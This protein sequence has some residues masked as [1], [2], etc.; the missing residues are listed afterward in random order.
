MILVTGATGFL[1]SELVKQLLQRGEPVRAIKRKSSVIPEI[2]QN[3]AGVEWVES[4]LLDYF[5][6]DKAFEGVNRVYHC[7]A[8]VAFDRSSK[9]KM[10]AANVEG[11]AHIVELCIT[12]GI[13]KLVHVSSVAALGEGKH[14]A[15]A[16]EK[17]HWQFNRSQHTY[18]IS[19]YESEM[20]VWRG[21]AEGLNA[22]IVNPSLIIGKNAGTSGSGQIFNLVKNGLKFYTRGTAGFVAVEDVARAMIML[23]ESDILSEGFIV[24][25]ENMSFKDLF[26]ETAGCLGVK[27]PAILARPWMMEIAWRLAELASLLTGRHY[28]LTRDTA[29]SSLQKLAYSNEK[30][31]RFFPGYRFKPISESI[32]EICERL[33]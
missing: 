14:G 2:L 31:L 6:L 27:P 10:L 23:M 32:S 4:D 16:T 7:A 20:E 11:T 24:S 1:G 9:K 25:A 3:E 12:H 28:G 21:I 29:R 5:A 8:M 19:K 18:S 22:V 30:F 33:R 26:R 17:D 13:E 15:P